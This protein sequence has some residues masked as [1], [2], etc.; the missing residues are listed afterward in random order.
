MIVQVSDAVR[1]SKRSP[2]HQSTQG[3][4]LSSDF[5]IK[6]MPQEPVP[7]SSK[8]AHASPDISLFN[9][10]PPEV[11]GKNTLKCN[12]SLD[13]NSVK[14]LGLLSWKFHVL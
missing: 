13:V 11:F 14:R 7:G 6:M 5:E 9:R 8:E 3:T 2:Q 12:V 1:Y 10:L 4:H